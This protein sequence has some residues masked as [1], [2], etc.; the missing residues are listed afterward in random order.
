MISDA[1]VL[2]PEFIPSEVKHRDAEVNT[3]SSV[4]RPLTDGNRADP[5]FL[6]G[7]SGTGKTCIAQFTV[8]RLREQVV[9]LNYQYVNCWEDYSRFKTLYS[10]LDGI[11][12]T[13]DIHRQ[14]TPKDVLLDRL[15]DYTG[16]PYV[17]ILDEV[18]QLQD[19]RLLYDLYRI[20]NLTMILIAN[21]ETEVFASVDD[22]LSSRLTTA[23]RLHFNH[24]S[25]SELN[26]I[27]TDRVR[28]GLDP[29]VISDGQ[30]S[31]ITSKAA[32]DA[33]IAIGVLRNAAQ[34]AHENNLDIISD[35]VIRNV[36]PETKS[37]IQQKTIDR[38]T[39][40]QQALFDIITE[41]GTIEPQPLYDEYENRVTDPKTKRTLRNHLSKLEHYNLIEAEGNTKAR[42]YR[43]QA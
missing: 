12:D 6:Y 16:P 39:T 29:G 34:R 19:K 20:Q 35:D 11:N 14:S 18:D 21:K 5:A 36:V 22:R 26:S 9:D 25:N 2:Q 31:Q 3:L 4:L 43:A 42:V 23:T 33:R 27:L 17:V 37:E 30:L 38:L 24:Y 10:I 7:P 15:R 1:R 41:H 8:E 40:H 32:G 13:I 28:W